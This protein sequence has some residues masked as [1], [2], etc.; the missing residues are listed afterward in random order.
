MFGASERSQAG[1]KYIDLSISFNE[2]HPLQVLAS[3]LL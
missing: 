2:T 3:K 1:P